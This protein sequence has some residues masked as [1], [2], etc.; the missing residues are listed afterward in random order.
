MQYGS[1]QHRTASALAR[2]IGVSWLLTG[3]LLASAIAGGLY[4]GIGALE[5][6]IAK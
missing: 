2:I 4:V 3:W 1:R 5:N 6:L